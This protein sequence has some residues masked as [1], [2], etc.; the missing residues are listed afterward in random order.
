MDRKFVVLAGFGRGGFG[1]NDIA[2]ERKLTGGDGV[3]SIEIHAGGPCLLGK[4]HGVAAAPMH[5]FVKFPVNRDPLK[6]CVSETEQQLF[7]LFLPAMRHQR[8]DMETANHRPDTTVM[9]L[10][11]DVQVATAVVIAPVRFTGV[12]RRV[13]RFGGVGFSHADLAHVTHNVF[14]AVKVGHTSK[15]RE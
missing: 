14:A 3:V 1:G 7:G 6:V 8:G 13:D 10:V 12:D 15:D 11:G 5:P 4:T 9:I 2:E